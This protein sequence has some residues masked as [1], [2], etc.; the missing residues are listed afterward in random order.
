MSSPS[1]Q[2]LHPC[3][4]PGGFQLLTLKAYS[5]HWASFRFYLKRLR[6]HSVPSVASLGHQF[7]STQFSLRTMLTPPHHCGPRR[8]TWA[9]LLVVTDYGDLFPLFDEAWLLHLWFW[10]FPVGHEDLV[11]SQQPEAASCL[12]L[13]QGLPWDRPLDFRGPIWEMPLAQDQLGATCKILAWWLRKTSWLG[14]TLPTCWWTLGSLR[15]GLISWIRKCSSLISKCS[16]HHRH[17]FSP[18]KEKVFSLLSGFSAFQ[19]SSWYKV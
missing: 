3:H 4:A 17:I 7:H 6:E 12:F 19:C 8:Y 5:Y 1:Q 13:S 14:Q 18:R 9:A 16:V 15:G 10:D 11:G 2:W